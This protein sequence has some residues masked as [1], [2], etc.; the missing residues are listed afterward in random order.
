MGRLFD[1]GNIGFLNLSGGW[2]WSQ[3][4]EHFSNRLS[5]PKHIQKKKL[6][7]GSSNALSFLYVNGNIGVV[8][9]FL[10]MHL[11]LGHICGQDIRASWV[12]FGTQ[13][14]VCPPVN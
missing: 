14:L 9:P 11:G 5:M 1:E 3:F 10:P 7:N 4:G 6:Q 12:A 2:A 13:A 8:H